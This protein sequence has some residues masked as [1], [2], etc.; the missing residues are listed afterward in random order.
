[1]KIPSQA[2]DTEH[3][4]TERQQLGAIFFREKKFIDGK[5]L[6]GGDAQILITFTGPLMKNRLLNYFTKYCLPLFGTS[7]DAMNT[8]EWSVYHSRLSF[9]MNAKIL[10]PKDVIG[11][12]LSAWKKDNKS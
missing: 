4:Y 12:A 1:M 5:F 11:A 3:F 8:D 2:Y 6:P 10:T 9:A 7:L